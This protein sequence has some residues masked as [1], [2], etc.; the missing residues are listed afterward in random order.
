MFDWLQI[1]KRYWPAI[2]LSLALVLILDGTISSLVTCHPPPNG[3]SASQNSNENCTVFNGP[4]ISLIRNIGTFFETHDKGIIA[5]FTVILAVSTIGLWLA[6]IG[7]YKSGERQIRT[8]RQVSAMQ[9]RLARQ[10]FKLA[11]ETA[12]RQAKEIQAQLKIAGDS[13][14]FTHRARV[15][16]LE[17]SVQRQFVMERGG[18]REFL[19][20]SYI[21][22]NSGNFPA[23]RIL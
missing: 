19:R 3:P 7:L 20:I 6:T 11:K 15:S 9:A 12:D 5:A 23:T 21:L 14:E 22:Q 17:A 18:K 13:L 16:I 10:Q 1:I 4:L 8:S 2:V